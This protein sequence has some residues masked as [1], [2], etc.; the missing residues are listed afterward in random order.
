MALGCAAATQ[1]RADTD[2]GSPSAVVR[3]D[4]TCIIPCR[5]NNKVREAM[6]RGVFASFLGMFVMAC[7]GCGGG[8]GG[9]TSSTAAQAA[10]QSAPTQVIINAQGDS[11]MW[12]ATRLSDGTIARTNPQVT[13]MMQANLQQ[14]LGSGYTVTVINSGVQRAQACMRINGTGV[15]TTTLATDLASIPA[16]YV[17]ENFG[18]ND[19][20]V[21]VG[22]ETPTQFQQCLEQF[23]DTVRAAGKTPILEEPNPIAPSSVDPVVYASVLPS[24][25]AVINAVAAEK[26]VPLIQQFQPIQQIQGWQSMLSDGVH[27]SPSLYAVKAQR[28]ADAMA[29]VITASR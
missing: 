5:D 8:G 26:G 27:P 10:S 29:A 21:V 17:L 4:V 20:N 9:G 16:Q 6:A 3:Q 15:Y 19:S 24:Y 18:I 1:A 28:E 22:P 12:S 11:T 14:A 2:S 7:S 25:V 23:V 13:Q